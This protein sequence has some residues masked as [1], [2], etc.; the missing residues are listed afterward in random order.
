MVSREIRWLTPVASTIAVISGRMI[1]Y[2]PVSSNMMT[3]A[4]IGA[5]A[6]PAKTA[7]MPIRAY[8]PAGPA[9]PGASVVQD[10]AVGRA[11]H[12]ADEQAGREDA[13]GAADADGQAGGDHLADQQQR[14]GSRSRTCPRCRCPAPGSRRR[15]S[16]AAPAAARRAAGRRPPGAAIPGPRQAQS[17][18]SSIQYRTRVKPTPTTPASSPSR[19]KSRYCDR[20]STV[21]GGQVQERL[22]AQRG[23][24]DHAGGDRGE[25]D[26]A[27]RLA[28]EVAQDELHREE[29]PGQRRVERRRD[30]A[31]RAAGDQQPHPLLADPHHP[32]QGRAERRADLHDRALPPDRPAAA[33]A[34]RRGQRLDRGDLR[35]RSARPCGRRRTSPPARRG[36]A[37]RGRRSAPAGRTASPATTGAKSDEPPA[38]ARARAGSAHA[39][40]RRSRRARTAPG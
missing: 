13:A 19:A 22:V 33:D 40:V 35:A 39:R 17:Q 30:A 1:E 6:E 28:V 29:D 31:G 24:A 25:H 26:H 23:A 38:Q 14:S 21:N 27:E 34:Q 8:A 11:E 16:P 7:P 4:V 5:R 20:W 15:T 2:S 3:T 18:A 9:M 32:A 10:L 36:R 12:R 37:P